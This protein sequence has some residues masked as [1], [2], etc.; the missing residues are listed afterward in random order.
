MAGCPGSETDAADASV[1]TPE[2]GL[3]AS[4]ASDA[5]SVPPVDA[6][7]ND[8]AVFDANVADAATDATPDTSTPDGGGACGLA[9]T[10]MLPSLNHDATF[11]QPEGEVRAIAWSDDSTKL[12]V[13]GSFTSVKSPDGAMTRAASNLVVLDAASGQPIAGYP[14]VTG[15]ID[16][17][18][19]SGDTVY[20]VGGVTQVNGMAR[21]R[22][23]A[24]SLSSKA[25]GA[26]APTFAG[27][28]PFQPSV[29]LVRATGTGV[30]VGGYFTSVGGTLR[31]NVAALDP[32]TGAAT[33]WAPPALGTLAPQEITVRALAVTSDRVF[34]GGSSSIDM[35]GSD[36]VRRR[37]VVAL[38]RTTGALVPWSPAVAPDTVYALEVAGDRLAIG[39][40]QTGLLSQPCLIVA[41]ARTGAVCWQASLG[42]A[43]GFYRVGIA[44][45]VVFAGGLTGTLFTAG[46]AY[47]SFALGS[48]SA[49]TWGADLIG[50]DGSAGSVEDVAVAPNGA[51]AISG[52]R[53]AKGSIATPAP[54]VMV[55]RP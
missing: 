2:A 34:V 51:V 31:A 7:A 28:T 27:T 23:F 1:T 33:A 41:D 18:S 20:V 16:D 47:K 13:G 52:N 25:L 11:W 14:S 8:A 45:G 4:D 53:I 40:P 3:D 35:T 15:D 38:D 30:F 22:A 37:N 6:S 36:G 39:T 50:G 19:V 5:S 32:A 10:P 9:S 29:R 21:G 24:F 55:Y 54:K 49:L 44:R 46:S 12:V 48:G 43:Q 26:W 17:I 42:N